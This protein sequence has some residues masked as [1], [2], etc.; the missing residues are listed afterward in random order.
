MRAR[1][2]GRGVR[3]AA[4]QPRAP[5]VTRGAARTRRPDAGRRC[6]GRGP[7]SPHLPAA[8]PA[9]PPAPPAPACAPQAPLT[10]SRARPTPRPRL[11]R[12]LSL[13]TG[14]WRAAIRSKDGKARAQGDLAGG[15]GRDPP[16]QARAAAECSSRSAPAAAGDAAR[17][18]PAAALSA[19][20]GRREGG[21]GGGGGGEGEEEKG[22]GSGRGGRRAARGPRGS[23]ATL[24]ERALLS[25]GMRGGACPS[26]S[27]SAP[28]GR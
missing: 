23:R 7:A 1:D 8:P 16:R 13:Q 14:A 3:G 9:G 12:L 20:G 6:G 25:P 28:G 4:R 18:A 19:E 15:A 22:G 27:A 21:E 26:G 10:R 5:G 17:S 11:Q 24:L 2:A